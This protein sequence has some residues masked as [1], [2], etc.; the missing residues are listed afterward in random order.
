MTLASTHRQIERRKFAELQRENNGLTMQL[1]QRDCVLFGILKKHGPQ[2][3]TT[4]ELNA[5]VEGS[6]IVCRADQIGQSVE[7]SAVDSDEVIAQANEVARN[8]VAPQ[9]ENQDVQ[10]EQG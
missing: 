7:F 5:F 9:P 10:K 3:L 4:D 2:T 1:K 6:A 8:D